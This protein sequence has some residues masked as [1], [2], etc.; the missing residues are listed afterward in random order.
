[1]RYGP[2]GGAKRHINGDLNRLEPEIDAD[3]STILSAV[4][5]GLS[6]PMRSQSRSNYC[7]SL[8]PIAFEFFESH[9]PS[10]SML[11]LA[12]VHAEHP[13]RCAQRHAAPQAGAHFMGPT[14]PFG[15]TMQL[16][17]TTTH[18]GWTAPGPGPPW[19]H[20]HLT[21]QQTSGRVFSLACC[22]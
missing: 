14:R 17:N 12:L 6:N 7:V 10:R 1:M 18:T 3:G 11:R 15:C 21:S 8:I 19:R 20:F 22:A 5:S 9:L 2:R 4:S 13:H 16:P